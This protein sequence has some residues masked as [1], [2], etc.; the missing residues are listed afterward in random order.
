M[1]S[2]YFQLRGRT[3]A[4]TGY[5]EPTGNAYVE[6]DIYPVLSKV[7]GFVTRL[8]VVDN[9]AVKAGEVLAEVDD[10]DYATKAAL[11]SD[12]RLHTAGAVRPP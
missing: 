9:Q 7:D 12:D 5:R 11:R 10:G 8:A 3:G 6:W 1:P 2:S 4:P